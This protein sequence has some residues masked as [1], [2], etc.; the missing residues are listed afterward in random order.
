MNPTTLLGFVAA[1]CTTLAFLPQAVKAH[2][3][4]Q[5]KDISLWMYLIFSTGV[6]LWFL[7]GIFLELWPVILANG[8]TLLPTLYILFLKIRHRHA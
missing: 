8:I 7:Y 6:F 4:Q 1:I 3:T 2:R 5:T